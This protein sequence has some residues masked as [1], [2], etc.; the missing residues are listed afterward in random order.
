MHISFDLDTDSED[1][2]EATVR[3]NV[4][5]GDDEVIAEIDEN[6]E[7]HSN[8]TYY[9]NFSW[10][11]SD[12][13]LYCFEMKIYDTDEEEWFCEELG[14]YEEN[15]EYPYDIWFVDVY[16]ETDDEDHTED[17]NET[18]HIYFDLESSV[19]Y[20]VSARVDINAWR[21]DDEMIDVVADV[22]NGVAP[23]ETY[24]HIKYWSAP[25]RDIF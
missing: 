2:V 6:Y 7:V 16:Y 23:N 15:E 20:Q 10:S 19:D 9:H 8:D 17:G 13:D 14:N 11:V 4:W 3:I 1:A 5:R 21:G 18:I 24:Y 12:R 22:S 25:D